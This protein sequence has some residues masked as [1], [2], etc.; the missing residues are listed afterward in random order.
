M[1]DRL[2]MLQQGFEIVSRISDQRKEHTCYIC[3]PNAPKF[4]KGWRVRLAHD[5]TEV[6]VGHDC[7]RRHLGVDYQLRVR[8]FEA[9]E[10]E[11]RQ[12]GL[13]SA[14]LG[15]R[16]A[17]IEAANNTMKDRGLVAI[18]EIKQA[19]T[20]LDPRA[21]K[22]LDRAANGAI[23]GVSN[24]EAFAHGSPR[25]HAKQVLRL[26]GELPRA[27]MTAH[28]G[29]ITKSLRDEI[30]KHNRLVASYGSGVAGI[31]PKGVAQLDNVMPMVQLRIED[32]DLIMM[33]RT[34]GLK[35]RLPLPRPLTLTPIPS[36]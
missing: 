36:P 5:G 29:K 9:K 14:Y 8:I 28:I 7:G 30:D 26:L 24:L 1:H 23:N 2:S 6:L 3:S 25:D 10:E 20:E 18:L 34:D 33:R 35:R 15:L 13:K 32:D 16:D 17:I 12:A 19:L 22:A 21:R 4:A 11:I 31:T 27:N